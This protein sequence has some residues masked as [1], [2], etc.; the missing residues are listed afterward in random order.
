MW[1]LVIISTRNGDRNGWQLWEEEIILEVRG[2]RGS[3]YLMVFYLDVK[4]T[5]DDEQCI[6][7]VGEERERGRDGGRGKVWALNS[8]REDG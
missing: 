1:L 4:V 5:R 2:L 6:A 3:V 7:G 8:A